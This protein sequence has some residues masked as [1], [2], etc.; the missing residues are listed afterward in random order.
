MAGQRILGR[1]AIASVLVCWLAAPAAADGLSRFKEAIKDA[2]PGALTYKTA[3]S[4]GDS[5][6][7]LDDVVVT[8][9]PGAT[10]GK[11]QP[12][13][14]KRI[15]VED[16][17]FAS[18]DKNAP[19]NFARVRVEGI[20]I[21]AKPAEGIDLSQLAGID[22]ILADFQLDYRLDPERKTMTL[23][24]LELDLNGLARVEL[25]MV[26]DGVG[27]D[28]V[29][30]PDAAMNDATLRTASFVFEDRSLLSKVLPAAAKMQSIE[31][32]ALVKMGKVLL[33][34]LRAGQGA[35]TLA[36]LDAVASYIDDYKQ[37]KGSLRITLNP[38]GKTSAAA[39]AAMKSADDAIKALG[40][41]VS[42]AGTKTPT[43][44]APAAQSPADA[45]AAAA[46]A[47]AAAAKAG[48]AK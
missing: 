21:G 42:Y 46:A 14:I 39:F 2:P 32:D 47:A 25:S 48:A 43:P 17:D 31:P 7:V 13:Q 37:P 11:T 34:G 24:R 19:P 10:P 44:A 18:I 5:G 33:D 15:S 23:N 40:L 16:F 35:A 45:V 29:G 1:L 6:F 26:L 28:A 4:L 30:N 9:P 36:V 41:V 38:P 20:A 27:A 12:I 8:P 22:K 3:K